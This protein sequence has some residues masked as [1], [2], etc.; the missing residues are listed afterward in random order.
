MLEL[1]AGAGAN[2][3][4]YP[5]GL[6]V[7]ATEPDEYMFAR[8]LK[9]LSKVS[10]LD[11]TLMLADA[12]ALPFTNESFDTVVG[13]LVF[14]TIPD[15][16]KALAE[17]MRVLKPGG[18]LLLM[19]HIRG[20]DSIRGIT[21]DIIAPVWKLMA[22]GCHINRNTTEM[23]GKVGFQIRDIRSH[24]MGLQIVEIVASKPA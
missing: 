1:G 10:T 21:E 15:P 13:T 7:I 4:H 24:F 9:R 20:P 18:K 16:M 5:A 17:A 23:I 12:Q 22:G 6:R 8:A 14:C 19:E 11:V 2:F 3:A